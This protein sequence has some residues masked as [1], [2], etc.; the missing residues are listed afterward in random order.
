MRE[1]NNMGQVPSI[2][3][4]EARGRRTAE[5]RHAALVRHV[6]TRLSR[7]DFN[8]LSANMIQEGTL[9]SAE[10]LVVG[11]ESTGPA[12]CRMFAGGNRGRLVVQLE[13]GEA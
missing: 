5:P 13:D 10:R 3:R 8:V 2:E 11:V 6:L 1:G 7:S 9:K 4:S 12:L